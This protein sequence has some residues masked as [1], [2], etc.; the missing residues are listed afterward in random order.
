LEILLLA[1]APQGR[2]RGWF[3]N[4]MA[5]QDREIDRGFPQKINA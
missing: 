1:G 5:A 4:S 3:R 2:C